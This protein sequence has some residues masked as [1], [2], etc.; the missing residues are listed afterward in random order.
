M[1]IKFKP[2]FLMLLTVVVQSQVAQADLVATLPPAFFSPT[3]TALAEELDRA[4]GREGINL[5][6]LN[7]MSLQATVS[8]NQAINNVSGYNIIDRGA[9]AEASGITSVIQN[10]GNNVVIQDSTIVNVTIVP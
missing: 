3:E 5:T 8:G 2:R 1:E 7:N 4:R 6:A 10:S 9:F